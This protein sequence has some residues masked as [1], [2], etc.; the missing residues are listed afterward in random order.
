M[1]ENWTTVKVV[2]NLSPLLFLYKPLGSL[3]YNKTSD[4]ITLYMF[5]VKKSQSEKWQET[6]AVR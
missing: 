3:I 2:A 1:N 6:K 4:F 5:G